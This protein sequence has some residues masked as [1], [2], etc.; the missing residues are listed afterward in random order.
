VYNV[1]HL[2]V[3]FSLKASRFVSRSNCFVLQFT[4]SFFCDVCSLCSSSK[5]TLIA[6]PK[7]NHFNPICETL[8]S[9]VERVLTNQSSTGESSNKN[10]Q[11]MGPLGP[12]SKSTCSVDDDGG[13]GQSMNPNLAPNLPDSI[14]LYPSQHCGKLPAGVTINAR[15][16]HCWPE[17]HVKESQFVVSPSLGPRA[18]PGSSPQRTTIR[19]R[20]SSFAIESDDSPIVQAVFFPLI[21]VILPR[22]LERVSRF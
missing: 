21:A 15:T 1:S 16:C 8:H 2:D 9:E 12:Q 13:L 17:F 5:E 4:N 11:P 7:F 14:L 10:G 22:W 18:P 6:R 20:T 3:L 19:D